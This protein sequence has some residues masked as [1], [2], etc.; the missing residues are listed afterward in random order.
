M[1]KIMIMF[2]SSKTQII[3][4]CDQD[5]PTMIE[6]DAPDFALGAI[7][8]QKFEEGKLHPCDFLSRELT[9]T[10]F[11]YDV[12]D[13]EMLAI[14]YALNKCKHFLQGSQ[15]QTTVFSD[16]QNLSYFSK[17]IKLNSR[18]ARWAELRKI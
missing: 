1:L 8:S 2:T 11:N 15:F 17:S 9:S 4:H 18:Q 6:T 14:V 13:N 12:N 7:L 5:T 3:Q 10:E 16:H